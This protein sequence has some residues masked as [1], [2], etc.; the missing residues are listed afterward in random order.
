MHLVAV[1][2]S[3]LSQWDEL[4]F[5]SLAQNPEIR[6]MKS[7][8]KFSTSLSH[9]PHTKKK[10]KW[11][12]FYKHKAWLT[13]DLSTEAEEG[14]RGTGRNRQFVECLIC[15][16]YRAKRVF[17]MCCLTIH[18]LPFVGDEAESQKADFVHPRSYSLW[19][20]ELE[21]EIRPTGLQGPCSH[22][23]HMGS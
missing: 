4:R 22:W 17:P 19:G 12:N 23:H 1:A 7:S 2:T 13:V 9:C 8:I 5:T 21:L 15:A 6:V 14:N 18:T 16:G 20:A 3:S 11:N 10:K